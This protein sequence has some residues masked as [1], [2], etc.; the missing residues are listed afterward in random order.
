MSLFQG[1]YTF[2]IF[3]ERRS[4]KNFKENSVLARKLSAKTAPIGDSTNARADGAWGVL[5][6][7]AAIAFASPYTATQANAETL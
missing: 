3:S 7:S 4:G 2:G 5:A 1:P 6:S